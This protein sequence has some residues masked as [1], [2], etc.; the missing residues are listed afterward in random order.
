MPARI[1]QIII[2]KSRP[3]DIINVEDEEEGDEEEWEVLKVREVTAS[4][5]PDRD[6]ISLPL[7]KSHTLISESQLPENM[8]F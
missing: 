5:C 6:L 2:W 3:P 8:Y 4:V 1:S 7:A